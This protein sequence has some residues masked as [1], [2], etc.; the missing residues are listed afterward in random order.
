VSVPRAS[1]Q[2]SRNWKAPAPSFRWVTPYDRGQFL[3]RT[4]LVETAAIGCTDLRL[5]Y[6]TALMGMA[7]IILLAACSNVAG[8]LVARAAEASATVGE[9]SGR[10]RSAF[11]DYR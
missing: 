8:L 3:K 10:L 5:Y 1:H 9:I 6:R 2:Q 7:G 4:A 11:G